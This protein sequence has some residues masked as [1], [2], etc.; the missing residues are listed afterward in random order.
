[1]LSKIKEYISLLP[2]V[3]DNADLIAEGIYNKLAESSLTED[4][5]LEIIKRKLICEGCIYNSKNAVNIKEL[6]YKTTREDDHCIQCGCNIE[7]KTHSLKS[8]CGIDAYNRRNPNKPQLA[9]KWDTYPN[10]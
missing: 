3:I 1:M 5:K 6:N 4:E 8:K 7:L 2:K 9:L 10:N